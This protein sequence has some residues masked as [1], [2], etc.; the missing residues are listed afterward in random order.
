MELEILDRELYIKNPAEQQS[1]IYQYWKTAVLSSF[2]KTGDSRGLTIYVNK[3][4]CII[5]I[6]QP[7]LHDHERAV[8]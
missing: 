3:K 4:A 8:N 2:Y 7:Y 1:P 6:T 5:R